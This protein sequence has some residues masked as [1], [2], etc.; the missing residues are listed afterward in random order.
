[1]EPGTQSIHGSY[2][3]DTGRAW[4][5]ISQDPYL[6]T[7]DGISLGRLQTWAGVEPGEPLLE[8]Q[9]RQTPVFRT[10]LTAFELAE[11]VADTIEVVT[12]GSDVAIADLR[13]AT[14][15]DIGGVEFEVAFVERGLPMQGTAFG[16]VRNG[17]LDL[18]LFVAPRE[19]YFE[20][21]RPMVRK[22]FDSVRPA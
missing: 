8:M 16:A 2:T 10:E 11:L 13:P 21:Y 20:H 17:K 4:T 5:R 6:W 9:D 14:F 19:Y 22:I 15:A 3:I 1:V 18:L 12:G 7:I